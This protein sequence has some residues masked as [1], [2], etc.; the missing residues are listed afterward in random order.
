MQAGRR[1]EQASDHAATQKLQQQLQAEQV[2]R[3]AAEGRV[4]LLRTKLREVADRSK[5][6]GNSL[7]ALLGAVRR[8]ADAKQQLTSAESQLQQAL[9]DAEAFLQVGGAGVW[10]SRALCAS[11]CLSQDKLLGWRDVDVGSRQDSCA[12]LPNTRSIRCMGVKVYV[13]TCVFGAAFL[14]LLRLLHVYCMC[15]AGGCCSRSSCISTA[16]ASTCTAPGR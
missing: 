10:A 2:A 14:S 11:S 6:R 16:T 9:Q 5:A 13:A 15:F 12:A 7:A 1:P 4:E 8:V 3:A